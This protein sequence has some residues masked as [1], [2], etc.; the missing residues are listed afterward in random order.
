[1]KYFFSL[2]VL[3][4]SVPLFVKVEAAGL[5]P[6]DVIVNTSDRMFQRL[7][8]EKPLLDKEPGKIYELVDEIV[9]PRFDFVRMSKLVLGKNWRQATLEQ[10]KDFTI[11]FRETLV[12]TYA[13]SLLEYVGQ[14][15]TYLPPRQL[16]SSEDVT[17]QSEIT[18][19]GNSPIEIAYRLYLVN[20]DWLVFDVA[21]EGVSLVI[22]YRSSY[23]QEIRK[24]GLDKLI[25]KLAE[26]NHKARTKLAKANEE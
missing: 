25:I 26:R 11:A 14:G 16:D 6:Y 13:N 17:V 18:R 23:D 21:I 12:R 15:I 7:K 1:M 24:G 5:S 19:P 8:I 10:R 4:I 22:N 2:V 9:I 20:D 3:V